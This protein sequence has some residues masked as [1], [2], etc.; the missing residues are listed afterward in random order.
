MRPRERR[1]SGQRDLLRPRLDETVNM[2]HPL[3]KLAAQIDWTYLEKTFGAAYKDGSGHP[4]L[5]TRLMAGLAILK[6]TYLP[7]YSMVMQ[8]FMSHSGS[9]AVGHLKQ[10]LH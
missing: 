10:I 9:Q 6:H 3:A 5:P 4:P 1:D 2:N 8:V 7:L